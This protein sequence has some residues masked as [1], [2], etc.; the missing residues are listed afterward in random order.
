MTQETIDVR[1]QLT[2]EDRSSPVIRRLI[3]QIEAMERKLK[4]LKNVGIANSVVDDKALAKLKTAGKE[5]QLYTQKYMNWAKEAKSSGQNLSNVYDSLQRDIKKVSD[6]YSRASKTRRAAMQEEL[7]GLLKRSAAVRS[8][9]NREVQDHQRTEQRK[10]QYLSKLEYSFSS[11][12][13]NNRKIAERAQQRD[14]SSRIKNMLR[15]FNMRDRHEK[16]EEQAQ[17]RSAAAAERDSNSRLRNMLRIFNMRDRYEAQEDK[18]HQAAVRRARELARQGGSSIFNGAQRTARAVT[19]GSMAA[20]GAGVF[21]ARKAVQASTTLD[22]EQTFAQIFQGI[23]R[24]DAEKLKRNFAIPMGGKLG[25]KPSEL[26]RAANEASQQGVPK[27]MIEEFTVKAVQMAK[28]MRVPASQLVESLGPMSAQMIGKGRSPQDILKAMNTTA[29]LANE[30]AATRES[31]VAAVRTGI[32]SGEALGYGLDIPHTMALMATLIEGGAQGQQASRA[33]GHMATRIAELPLKEQQLHM[34]PNAMRDPKNRLFL[35]APRELG[36]SSFSE[37]QKKFEADPQNEIFRLLKSFGNIKD[38]FKRTQVFSAVFGQ[39]F[40]RF[41]LNI[42]KMSGSVEK[43]IKLAMEGYSQD[44]KNDYLTKTFTIWL[45]SFES[46]IERIKAHF[47]PL[48]AEIGDAFKEYIQ[49]FMDVWGEF[50]SNLNGKV[51]EYVQ[52]T[53][54]GA[55]KGFGYN[56]FKDLLHDLIPT[57]GFS[58]SSFFEFSKGFVEGIKSIFGM[59]KS[60]GSFFTGGDP[61]K[62]G[63]LVGQIIAL[64]FAL[65]FLSPVVA[66][67]ASLAWGI[68]AITTALV[69]FSGTTVGAAILGMGK[70][71]AAKTATAGAAILGTTGGVAAAGAAAALGAYALGGRDASSGNSLRKGG[72]ATQSEEDEVNDM[73]ELR[74]RLKGGDGLA[75]KMS[76]DGLG[77]KPAET[78]SDIGKGTTVNK[79]SL[80]NPE[81]QVKKLTDSFDRTGANIQ[82]AAFNPASGLAKVI[83]GPTGSSG[84]SSSGG[85]SSGGSSSG[86]SIMSIPRV[87]GQMGGIGGL[88]QSIPGTQLP[89]FGLGPKGIIGGS[90]GFGGTPGGILGGI[91]GSGGDTSILKR[92]GKDFA[93]VPDEVGKS[94]SSGGSFSGPA[95]TMFDAIIR[96]EGT[97]KHG[98]PYDTSLGYLKSPKPLSQMTMDEA[99]SWGDHIRKGTSI[100]LRT[101]SSA[102]GA[103]QIVNTTQR[104]AMK[105]L[106]LKGSDAFDET[107]QQRMAQWI[108][109][110]Q[111]LGAWEGLKI[112]PTQMGIAR[113][114]IGEGALSQVPD[115]ASAV[116]KV[117]SPEQSGR[118]HFDG[119]MGGQNVNSPI[120]MNI[121]GGGHDPEAL[122]SLVQRRIE[123]SQ[124]WRG[125]DMEYDT[126]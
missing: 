39:E 28:I 83:G 9:H 112:N 55:L 66:V 25:V 104:A 119:L 38:Q 117:P 123:E 34:R 26:L 68:T 120:T 5:V 108:A 70:G 58:A 99:L 32:G 93:A 126:A 47:E 3:S 20:A 72:G 106:G 40:A 8:L 4:S 23:S 71:A 12:R 62:M 17:R 14:S 86:G 60:L 89:D 27:E 69:A 53:L 33:V 2:A 121:H 35:S 67:L 107:N 103:F 29:L 76:F 73:L 95:K 52:Q 61:K 18:A 100:G 41:I 101:N 118:F 92:G 77:F 109:R 22:T 49:D 97:G 113:R 125:H 65:H 56:S 59:F 15:I 42:E 75:K 94:F 48:L 87:G 21:G 82:L 10:Y 7:A 64:S 19:F 50:A 114:A 122:A 43:N 78:W 79:A 124:K 37:M 36:Y 84:G 6:S 96:S 63:E 1:A 44:P 105:A 90:R 115:A 16:E 30:T 74:K 11:L 91:P 54:K 110:K 85:S 111:G 13:D 51:K 57:G 102:K 88:L 45:Q 80:S 116:S 46:I 81:R 31:M 24:E 98:N